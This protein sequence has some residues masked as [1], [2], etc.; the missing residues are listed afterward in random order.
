MRFSCDNQFH[1]LTEEGTGGSYNAFRLLLLIGHFKKT[2]FG[3]VISMK[4]ICDNF[5]M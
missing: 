3:I 5:F 2:L 4:K 1:P